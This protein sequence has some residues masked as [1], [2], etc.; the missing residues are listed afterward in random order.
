MDQEAVV[1]LGLTPAHRSFAGHVL[2]LGVHVLIFGVLAFLAYLNQGGLP[3]QLLVIYV[4][5]IPLAIAVDTALVLARA[6]QKLGAHHIVMGCLNAALLCGVG[7][8]LLSF[9]EQVFYTLLGSAVIV[10]VTRYSPAGPYLRPPS[11]SDLAAPPA[12]R[13]STTGRSAAMIVAGVVL[14]AVGVAL[15]VLAVLSQAQRP[16]GFSLTIGG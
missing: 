4:S 1:D 10:W 16:G 8:I 9:R 7:G 5:S 14:T 11:P 3:A 12:G 15:T 6:R 2:S 13:Q